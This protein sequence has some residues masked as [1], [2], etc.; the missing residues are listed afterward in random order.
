MRKWG[1]VVLTAS[2]VISA[3]VALAQTGLYPTELTPPER[4]SVLQRPRPE[5]SPVGARIGDFFLYPSAEADG[6]WDS[7]VYYAPHAKSDFYTSLRPGAAL[8]SDWGTNQ[9][10]FLAN[11]EVRRFATQVSENQTNYSLA[12]NGRLDILHGEYL[13]GGLEFQNNHE[14]R[15]AP[16]SIPTQLHPTEYQESSGALKF[17]R[18]R[19]IVGLQLNGNV[20]YYTY[21]NVFTTTGTQLRETDR[22]RV[23]IS[24][25][26]KVTYQIVPGYHAFIAG[27]ANDRVYEHTFDVNGLKRSSHGFEVDVGTDVLITQLITGE[28]YVGYLRQEYDDSRLPT[29][30]SPGFGGSLLWNVTESTSIRANASRTIQE[31]DLFNTTA[32]A[33]VTSAL[34]SAVGVEVEQEVLPNVLLTGG[35][36]FTSDDYQGTSRTDNTVEGDLGVT[37][38]LNRMWSTGLSVAYQNR[39]SNNSGVGFSRALFGAKIRLQY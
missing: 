36:S 31:V 6:Y 30:S 10:D 22:N 38:L 28:V 37:Y 9:L 1:I 35:G 13:D 23:E 3:H 34:Q 21:N 32:A 4:V 8:E 18:E 29:I 11:A 2:I 5:Y 7:N 14:E 20:N 24:G 16:S 39:S 12:S 26:P 25:G 19:G 27:S 15:Y 17:V 33:S